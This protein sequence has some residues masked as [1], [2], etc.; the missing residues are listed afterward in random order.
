M[1]NSGLDPTLKEL[2]GKLAWYIIT[3]WVIRNKYLL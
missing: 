2:H 1:R 3:I